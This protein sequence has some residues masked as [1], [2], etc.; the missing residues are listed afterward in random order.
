MRF[1]TQVARKSLFFIVLVGALCVASGP[2]ATVFHGQNEAVSL[3][4][5]DATHTDSETYILTDE[6]AE[7]VEGAGRSAL[8][9]RL[10]TIHRGWKG[11]AFLGYAH[12]DVHTVR[13]KAEAFM[14]VLGPDAEITQVRV[15]AFY[16][17]LEYMPSGRWYQNF[18]GKGPGDDLRISFD[19]D[20]VTGATLTT[21]A[22]VDSVRRMLAY[23]DVL[24]E[25]D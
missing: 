5:P 22:T 1:W 2:Y 24:L 4:F 23:Y 17:P 16:E 11:D 12:I 21:R 10:I 18:F 8:A 6:Q 15:L 19:I 9:T 25:S 14:V 13:T 20:A 7:K 3:A